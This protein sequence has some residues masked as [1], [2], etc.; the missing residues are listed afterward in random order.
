MASTDWAQA[1][2]QVEFDRAFRT[3]VQEPSYQ[4]KKVFVYIWVECRYLTTRR[5]IISPNQVYSMG[6]LHQR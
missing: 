2:T 6:G 4:N 5:A 1:N 3:I